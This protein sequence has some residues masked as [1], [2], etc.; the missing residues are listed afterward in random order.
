[1]LPY[2]LA[3]VLLPADADL[4]TVQAWLEVADWQEL[5]GEY[6]IAPA[7]PAVTWDDGKYIF[8]WGGK[9]LSLIVGGRDI[10]IYGKDAYFPKEPVE[11]ISVGKF[12]Q[13]KL[14]EVKI[15]Q[16][17]YNPVQ[18]KVRVL[19]SGRTAVSVVPSES[20]SK[21]A[22]SPAPSGTSRFLPKLL[23]ATVNPQDYDTFY[24]PQQ[25]PAASV[26]DYVII[27]TSTI[28][29]TSTKFAAFI[30]CK[31]NSGSGHIVRVVTQA[32]TADDTHYVSGT[33]ADERADNIRSWLQSHYLGDGIECVLLIGD[34]HPT[35]FNSSTS[36]P[37]RM[38]RPIFKIGNTPTDMFFAELSN[39]WDYDGDGYYGEYDGDY[40]A[41]GADKH[42]E[43]QVGRIPF[44]GSY[45]DLN[46]IL[47]KTIDYSSET[48]DLTW[49]DKVLI[50]GAISNFGPQDSTGDGDVDDPDDFPYA[51]DRTFGADWGQEIKSLASSQGF[52]AYTLYEKQGYYSDGSAYPLTACDSPLTVNNFVSQWQNNYGF[53][54]WWGHGSETIAF[55][56]CWTSDSAYPNICG[57]HPNHDETIR[58]TLF[59]TSFC[60]QLDDTHPSFVV[61]VS[62][63]NAWPENSANLAY[64]LLKH[65]AIGTFA[66]TRVTFYQKGSWSTS[67]GPSSGDSASYGYYIF[68]QM[69][70]GDTAAAALNWC[71]GNFGTDWGSASWM[72]MVTINLYGDPGLS[73]T[74]PPRTLWSTI[75]GGGG[76]SSGG[77]FAL[78]GTIGQ[79]D[80]GKMAGGD[81]KLSGG[82]WPRGPLVSCFVNFEDFAE[83]AMYWL[84]APC[85]AGNN[86]CQGADLD[87]STAV[88]LS[89]VR[90]LAYWWLTEC[91][92]DWPWQ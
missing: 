79:P 5:P 22:V 23:S 47:Q 42:C 81:Y 35:S 89:D 92:L 60:P 50:A 43:V 48:G 70:Q 71:R 65:G 61:Q 31:E 69:A 76:R 62:C 74:S 15:W 63:S 90:E 9:D 46:S 28:R 14:V 24:G 44:Y 16:K 66:G 87:W 7:S 56:L 10:S 54:T 38:C 34:P 78:V 86:W 36:I 73:C 41:G 6:E 83:F 1:M 80:A 18:R 20:T 32:A 30:A 2:Y 3:R 51:S 49:R 37:M 85:N 88:G 26:A 40:C 45:G 64:S 77:D 19:S 13:W 4:A 57:N 11:I 82:F 17:A 55:R 68:S 75:D 39:T 72:N 12:R 67:I 33:T 25:A 59:R 52:D 8:D 27:T 91:P 29:D 84:D 58:Y 53:V 21:V